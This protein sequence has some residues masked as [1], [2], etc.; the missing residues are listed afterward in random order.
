VFRR[1][2]SPD[3]PVPLPQGPVDNTFKY[4]GCFVANTFIAAAQASGLVLP[5]SD[6]NSCSAAAT[7]F[8]LRYLGLQGD[9][10]YAANTPPSSS[11]EAGIGLC[12]N[13]CPND[14]TQACG[15]AISQAEPL[16][17]RQTIDTAD[18]DGTHPLITLFEAAPPPPVT[19]AP[20]P[21][22]PTTGPTGP[23]GTFVEGCFEAG[24]SITNAV[25]YGRVFLGADLA[26]NSNGAT[27]CVS[28]CSSLNQGYLYAFTQYNACYCSNLPPTTP[29]TNQNDCNEACYNNPD[30]RCGGDTTANPDGSLFVNLFSGLPAYQVRPLSSFVEGRKHIALLHNALC[31]AEFW[32]LAQTSL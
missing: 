8:G 18:G 7:V 12:A 6:I 4:G 16:Q 9:T 27:V 19:P 3:N 32:V 31:S 26:S 22:T 25:A 20:P 28:A 5:N 11:L 2:I 23:N 30:E 24:G 1:I 17:K 13:P 29:A 14:P 10:C 21:D 15:G